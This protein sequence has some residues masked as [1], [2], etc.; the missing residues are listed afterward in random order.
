[1]KLHPVAILLAT[2]VLV[3]ASLLVGVGD[4][5]LG[6]LFSL[7]PGSTLLLV[8]SRI[9]RTLAIMLAGASI[10][11]AGLIMQMLARNRFAE[12]STAGTVD[13]ASLGMLSV[14]LLAPDLPIIAKMLIAAA[15][16]LAGTLMFVGVLSRV[17]LRSPLIVP[18]VG[19]M[20]G[21]VIGAL[22]SFLAY[23]Y[24]LLQSLSAWT[25]GDFSMVLQ[26]RYELLWI[27][28]GL[29]AVGYLA[30]DRLTVAGLG[31]DFT[32]N[33]GLNYRNV[34][35]L[36]LTIVA[37]ITALVVTT[38]GM[39]PFLGL[40]VP[41]IVSLFIGDNLRRSV[42]YTA[43]LGAGMVLLCDLAG[44]LLNYPFEIPI[45]TV[46]GVVGSGLFLDLLLRK[47]ARVG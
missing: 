40:V 19:L 13:A 4:L 10:A 29:A 8:T 2:L 42:P 18:L 1:M 17:P 27:A 11:I 35:A 25:N 9:P 22:T 39:I 14:T 20:L 16:A 45:G 43:L 7:E 41:N 34:M 24:D 30:A 46:M 15:F 33:L 6:G 28:F 12:P 5:S 3:V 26:G 21:N 32:T 31:R 38:I 23:R 36:G 44:R 47:R 37:M